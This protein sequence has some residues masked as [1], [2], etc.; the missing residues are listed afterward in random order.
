M[1]AQWILAVIIFERMS[2]KWSPN[3]N[4]GYFLVVRFGAIFFLLSSS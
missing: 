4:T 3:V 1:K 2:E